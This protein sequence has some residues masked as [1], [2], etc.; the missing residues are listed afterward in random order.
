MVWYN[1]ILY[2]IGWCDVVHV[3]VWYSLVCCV[4]VNVI[5]CGVVLGV[6]WYGMVWYGIVRYIAFLPVL[7]RNLVKTID[8][9]IIVWYGMF[10]YSVIWCGNIVY[11]MVWYCVVWYGMIWHDMTWHDMIWYDMIWYDMIWYDV[12]K[13]QTKIECLQLLTVSQHGASHK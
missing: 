4:V 6:V 13:M 12:C 3:M 1:M 7:T 8:N 9:S 5:H 11:D 10:Y 2:S